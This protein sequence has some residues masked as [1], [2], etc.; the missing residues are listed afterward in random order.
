MIDRDFLLSDEQMRHFIVNGYIIL[1]TDH[2][3]NFHEAIFNQTETA[4]EKEGNPGNN[5]LPR[6]P[7]IQELFDDP[8][9]HGALISLLGPNYY[10]HPHRHCH[11]NPPG[12]Q[13]QNMHIDS[14][15]RRRHRT[16][17]VMALYYPQD[18]PETLGPTG[19]L[20][21]SQYYNTQSN[22]NGGS[23][24]P[25]CGEAGT[26][27]IIHYDLWHRATPNRSDQ[28][29][30]MMKFLFT[31]ME[32]PRH[33]AWN[34]EQA[35]W[36]AAGDEKHQPMW[37]HLWDWHAGKKNG[38]VTRRGPAGAASIAEQIE[39]LRDK[40]E[41]VCLHA[42]YTL[43][44]MG[45]PA[46]PALMETLAEESAAIRR[47]A[48]YALTAI[49]AP[50]V[51]ALIEASSDGKEWVRESAVE[52]LGDMGLPAQEAIPALS[53]GLGDESEQVRR[54]AADGLGIIGQSSPAAVAPLMGALRDADEWVRRNASLALARIGPDAKNAVPALEAA[55]KDEN[56]YVRANA[57]ET[58]H[59]IGTP[60]A[61]EV[62]T[63]FLM[64]SRWCPS[65]TRESAY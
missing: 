39:A 21:G 38:A 3:A 36:D 45:E 49:G 60:G 64:T 14:W 18:T 20:P 59:R 26:V 5:L 13:G 55:L 43:G 29:R 44:A 11:Y 25:L 63:R 47:N 52:A 61:K 56:R 42:A 32:E 23:E 17:W 15:T 51:P 62:L 19:I 53:Q 57:A 34:N 35:V 9:I 16:R 58:L 40:S 50:A 12:S 24:M 4:F 28:K 46:V 33:P 65:T 48:S 22:G 6:I 37:T 10:M 8:T 30:Y 27:A 31:R 1:K 2:P 54:N 41:V 7:M